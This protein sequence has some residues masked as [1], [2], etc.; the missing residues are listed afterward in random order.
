MPLQN[1]QLPAGMR[2]HLRLRAGGWT[3]ALFS[4]AGASATQEGTAVTP[5][6]AIAVDAATST[7]SFT[8][9]AS[10]FGGRKSL[11]GTKIY[12]TTWD[13]DSGYRALAPAAQPYV[14]GGGPAAG[15]RVMDDSAVIVLP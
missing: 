4:A 9:S 7:V 14:F 6:P 5:A 13:Y 1:A 12:V 15:A 3:H 2:W 10:A 11:S 8:F